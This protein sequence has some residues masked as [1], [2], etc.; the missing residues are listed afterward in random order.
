MCAQVVYFYAETRTSHTTYAD[1]MEMFDFSN[2]QREKHFPDGRSLSNSFLNEAALSCPKLPSKLPS[3]PYYADIE[4]PKG[5]Y[6]PFGLL[7]R[8]KGLKAFRAF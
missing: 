2:G 8:P 6:R 1:G 5:P 3:R 7:R 4:D